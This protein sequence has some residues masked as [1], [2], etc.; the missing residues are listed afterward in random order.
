MFTNHGAVSRQLDIQADRA[1]MAHE[2]L[3]SSDFHRSPPVRSLV[4]MRVVRVELFDAAGLTKGLGALENAPSSSTEQSPIPYAFRRARLTARVSATRISAPCTSEETFEGS[5]S[6][7]P[8]KPFEEE[9]LKTMAL[10]TQRADKG[11]ENWPT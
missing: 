3:F 10:K 11:S 2:D 1:R 4:R 7:Y 6:P 9:F 8:M 5:A